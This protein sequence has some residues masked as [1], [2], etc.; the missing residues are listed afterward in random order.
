M[1]RNYTET[2]K[3][4]YPKVTNLNEEN[5]VFG[6]TDVLKVGEKEIYILFLS[7]RNGLPIGRIAN[8]YFDTSD[9]QII[10]S[11]LWLIDYKNDLLKR[12]KEDLATRKQE[13]KTR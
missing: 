11:P 13:T 2:K 5:S 12:I 9:K 8:T 10:N 7:D 4:E 3:E 6:Y 1:K